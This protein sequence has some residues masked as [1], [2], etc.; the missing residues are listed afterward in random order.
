[1]EM[2]SAKREAM[3]A[4]ETINRLKDQLKEKQ[5]KINLYTVECEAL[6]KQVDCADAKAREKEDEVKLCEAEYDRK[7]KL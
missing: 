7:L 5:H 1:M 6:I 2:R 4:S 3:N